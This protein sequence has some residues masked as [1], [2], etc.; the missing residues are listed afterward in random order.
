VET[1]QAGSV[2]ESY[3]AEIGYFIHL[4]DPFGPADGPITVG[5][6]SEWHGADGQPQWVGPFDGSDTELSGDG[7]T[8]VNVFASV[9]TKV[10]AAP[11]A[12]CVF[13][14]YAFAQTRP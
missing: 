13:A 3:A 5:F 4:K 10:P 7:K 14:G 6:G 11:N 9:G 12:D 8:Y 2:A 1:S